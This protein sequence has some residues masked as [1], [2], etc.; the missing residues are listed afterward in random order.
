MSSPWENSSD[1]AGCKLPREND[2]LKSAH[3]NDPFILVWIDI[4]KAGF[5]AKYVRIDDGRFKVK[6][7]ATADDVL[8]TLN[9]IVYFSEGA[10]VS[11]PNLCGKFGSD[12]HLYYNDIDGKILIPD[13]P[14]KL[15]G[16]MPKAVTDRLLEMLELPPH[17][18][19]PFRFITTN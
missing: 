15:D 5:D 18:K 10:R 4:W 14:Y 19:A 6:E 1:W 8:E 11:S 2:K 17:W 7:S 13:E 16:K 12:Q 9:A 3:I